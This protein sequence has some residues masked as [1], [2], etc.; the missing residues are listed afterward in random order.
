LINCLLEIFD[1]EL[2]MLVLILL[3]ME[4]HDHAHDAVGNPAHE[5]D[6]AAVCVHTQ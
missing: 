1:G 3:G 4:C 6:V 2:A 5:D